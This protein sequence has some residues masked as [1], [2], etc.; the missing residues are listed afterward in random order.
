[1]T[2]T[3]VTRMRITLPGSPPRPRR[4]HSSLA[5]KPAPDIAQRRAAAVLLLKLHQQQQGVMDDRGRLWQQRAG[6]GGLVHEGVVGGEV[7]VG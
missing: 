4:R 1:M 3:T 5:C 2:T 7:V 6:E